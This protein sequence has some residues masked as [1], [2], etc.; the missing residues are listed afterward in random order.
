MGILRLFSKRSSVG[1]EYSQIV[2]LQI[3]KCQHCLFLYNHDESF[4]PKNPEGGDVIRNREQNLPVTWAKCCLRSCLSSSTIGI[5][6]VSLALKIFGFRESVTIGCGNYIEFALFP[7]VITGVVGTKTSVGAVSGWS[8]SVTIGEVGRWSGCAWFSS[9]HLSDNQAALLQNQSLIVFYKLVKFSTR[10]RSTNSILQIGRKND[11]MLQFVEQK[12]YKLDLFH[13]VFF[14]K[15]VP[16]QKLQ[17][18]IKCQKSCPRD[19]RYRVVT[20]FLIFGIES[21][22]NCIG[23]WASQ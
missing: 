8:V 6:P 18:K 15:L 19:C 13:K 4:C 11:T 21:L 20:T 7:L 10:T 23:L 2:L 3:W 9:R 14:Y 5:P 22:V 1:R 12:L 17:L 16:Y